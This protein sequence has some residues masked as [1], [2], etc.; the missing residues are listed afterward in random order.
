MNLVNSLLLLTPTLA[1]SLRFIP[2]N[3]TNYEYMIF[4]EVKFRLI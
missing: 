3:N 2:L 1:R 4:Y